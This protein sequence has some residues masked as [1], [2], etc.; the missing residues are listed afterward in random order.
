MI[1]LQGEHSVYHQFLEQGNHVSVI[2]ALL[3][4]GALH[5]NLIHVTVDSSK[6]FS[7]YMASLYQKCNPL[8]ARMN[9]ILLLILDNPVIHHIQEFKFVF[10]AEGIFSFFLTTVIV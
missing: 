10:R 2:C 7:S 8:M 1:T 3:G 4:N 9:I 6:L 5:V